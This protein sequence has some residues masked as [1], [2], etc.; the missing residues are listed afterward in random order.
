[1]PKTKPM[2]RPTALPPRDACKR[3]VCYRGVSGRVYSDVY[4]VY[5]CNYMLDVGASRPFKMADCPGF[6]KQEIA[7][8]RRNANQ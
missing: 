8:A 7:E 2:N 3:C 5:I 1:M 4:D 6:T